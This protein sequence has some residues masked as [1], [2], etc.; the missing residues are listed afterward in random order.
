MIGSYRPGDWFSQK[1]ST[2][3]VIGSHRRLV[4]TGRLVLTEVSTY[5]CITFEFVLGGGHT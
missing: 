1:V 3:R 5:M 4:Q 2:D